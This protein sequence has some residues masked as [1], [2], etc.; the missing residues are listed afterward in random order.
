[1][2]RIEEYAL[3]GD[4]QTAA[5]V[6]KDG[7]ID[8][9][10]LRRF[11]SPACFASLL[12]TPD[13]GRWLIV[14]AATTSRP[15]Q[16]GGVRNWDYRYCWLRDATLVRAPDGRIIGRWSDSFPPTTCGSQAPW[17]RSSGN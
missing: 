6:G 2:A 14:A 10:C 4:M 3:I 7:S 17:R 1:M 13:H 9:L 15:E 12:G 11:D 16:L 8:W 5:L